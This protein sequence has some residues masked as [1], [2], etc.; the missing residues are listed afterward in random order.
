MWF[1]RG[2]SQRQPIP[3][4]ASAFRTQRRGTPYSGQ[5]R[6]RRTG[7]ETSWTE[8]KQVGIV[9]GNPG[10][11]QG[12]PD[13]GLVKTRTR[14]QGT[15]FTGYGY[16]YPSGHTDMRRVRTNKGEWCQSRVL[17]QPWP[18]EPPASD[19]LARLRQPAPLGPRRWSPGRKTK[20]CAATRGATGGRARTQHK[21]GRS[22]AQ[23]AI[24]RAVAQGHPVHLGG[25]RPLGSWRKP[26]RR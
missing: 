8:T 9:T 15:G 20:S 11:F 13:P 21:R 6:R 19:P 4:Y 22:Q 24:A 17:H 1:S 2:S 3:P 12:Y 14:P 5:A 26:D 7:V 23:L 18:K 10:V 16:G 25:T